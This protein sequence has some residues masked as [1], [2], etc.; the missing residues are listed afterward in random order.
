MPWTILAQ[1]W[2][3]VGPNGGWINVLARDG[4]GNIYAG[5]YVGGIYKTS[6]HGD[7]W[8]RFCTDTLTIDPLS[9]A[10]NPGGHVFVGASPGFHRS[11]NGGATWQKLNNVLNT[12]TVEALVVLANGTILAGNWGGGVFRS[13]DNGTTFAA[14]NNGLSNTQV[15]VPAAPEAGVPGF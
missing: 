12:R 13:T 14:T 6:D 9:I 5:T 15:R 11:T 8:V 7:T 4:S 1:S 10:I 2:T 3:S